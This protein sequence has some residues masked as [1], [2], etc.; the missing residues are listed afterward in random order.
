MLVFLKLGGS[1]ITDK[2]RAYTV[3][4]KTLAR[5][6]RE[7]AAARAGD[8]QLSIL[9]GHGSG[10]FGH[11][12]A[13]QYGIRT[14]VRDE[15][16]WKG[17]IE[18]WRQAR[19][20]NQ[21]VVET[22]LEANV[23]LIAFPPSACVIAEAGK[24]SHWHLDPLRAAL[25]A[26]LVPVVQ[27]DTVFDRQRGGII[28]STEEMF[29]YLA[30]RLHPQR[31]LIAG[32]EQGVWADYPHCRRLI[33]EITPANQL[34]I[35]GL[36][37]ASAAVDVTGGMAEKVA[38]MLRLVSQDASLEALIFSGEEA[39]TVQKVLRGSSAGTTI[40]NRQTWNASRAIQG[41]KRER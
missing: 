2:N 15:D 32:R 16:D 23:P 14:G 9:L 12:A 5:L 17:F 26:N 21:I 20:L 24:L 39:G 4:R 13:R 37:G 34:Q 30:P 38:S 35:E 22:L 1:L 6:G 41:E 28:L 40:H 36:L 29:E 19:A 18:V 33:E 8:P 7:I 10:S 31:I 3:C 11:V 25:T 27:G